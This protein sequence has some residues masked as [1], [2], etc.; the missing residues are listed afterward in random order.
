MGVRC[1]DS[2]AA[3]F[4][5]AAL[6][7]IH[8]EVHTHVRV[9]QACA[10]CCVRNGR[11]VWR[12]RKIQS[13]SETGRAG[14]TKSYRPFGHFRVDLNQRTLV[15]D[16][17]KLG[18]SGGS[19]QSL[20]DRLL[21]HP[22]LL[23]SLLSHWRPRIPLSELRPRLQPQAAWRNRAGFSACIPERRRQ[24][25]IALLVDHRHAGASRV[26]ICKASEV[27]KVTTRSIVTTVMS[28]CWPNALAA[29]AIAIAGC[30]EISRPRSKPNSSPF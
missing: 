16:W 23:E 14:T 19:G 10:P 29:S 3:R 4:E 13:P 22:H 25:W 12:Q 30:F 18:H 27:S 26:A 6:S 8:M 5:E 1:S 2:L 28:S 15:P 21:Q 7:P 17:G 24:T 9:T 11:C 20:S